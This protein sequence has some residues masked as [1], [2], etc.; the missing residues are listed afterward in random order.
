MATDRSA[1]SFPQR[2]TSGGIVRPILFYDFNSP[3]D[4]DGTYLALPNDL[5]AVQPG[6][7]VL[8]GCCGDDV[9]AK[10]RVVA[11]DPRG[12]VRVKAE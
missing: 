5:V 11:L 10:G 7:E 1:A 6:D 3:P 9:V 4:R 8:F 12:L 2:T